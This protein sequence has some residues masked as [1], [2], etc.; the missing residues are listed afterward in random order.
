MIFLAGSNM[1]NYDIS[2]EL[3]RK[4]QLGK[5][6]RHIPLYIIILP[7]LVAT[8][9]FLY[10]PMFGLSMAFMD[11][12]VFKGFDSPWVGF[13]N[14]KEIISLPAFWQATLNTLKLS[15]LN[16]VVVFPA[17][18]IFALLL[19]ELGHKFFKRVVQTVSYLPH[20]LSWIA[21]VG[22]SSSVFSNY[23]IVND[24]RLAFFGEGTERTMFLS[25]QGFF[26]PHV[27]GLTLWK[28]LG[29]DS[30]IYIS[31]ISGIDDQLYE[32]AAIDGAGRFRRCI[33]ITIPSILPTAVMLFILKVGSLFKDNFDLIY[34]LQNPFIDFETISTLIYK[35]GIGAGDYSISTGIGLM[36]GVIGFGLVMI[37]NYFSR[38][39]NDVALW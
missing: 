15:V 2:K 23:G 26:I 29:W 35:Q 8:L 22:I 11:Y 13:A 4:R 36:Q 9:V 14:F 5:I 28:T 3:K 12:D 27:I 32:A 7:M 18:I 34:G 30:I 21:V 25:Q 6:K 39:V 33:S 20:F 10:V 24:L 17:P 19:N 1:A 37:A 31:A 38:K 16:M